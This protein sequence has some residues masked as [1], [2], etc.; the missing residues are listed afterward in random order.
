MPARLIDDDQERIAQ[1]QALFTTR[2]DCGRGLPDVH[3]SPRCRSAWYRP[4][5]DPPLGEFGNP[6]QYVAWRCKPEGAPG[7]ID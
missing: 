1:R 4:R 3:A 7:G 6:A 5:H 2:G